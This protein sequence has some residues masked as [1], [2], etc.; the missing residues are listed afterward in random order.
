M[1]HDHFVEAMAS[2]TISLKQWPYIYTI[3]LKGTALEAKGCEPLKL[4][5]E[6]QINIPRPFSGY[7]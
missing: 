3:I 2:M 6:S 7:G 1:N 4:V 5:S